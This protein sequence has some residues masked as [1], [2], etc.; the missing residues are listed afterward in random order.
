MLRNCLKGIPAL[1]VALMM[2]ASMG[3]QVQPELE[4]KI[5]YTGEGEVGRKQPDLGVHLAQQR[6]RQH[7]AD[8]LSLRGRERQDG[9]HLRALDHADLHYLRLGRARRL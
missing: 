4:V 3:A 9:S 7:D 2:L 5:T 1:A 6:L 8:R